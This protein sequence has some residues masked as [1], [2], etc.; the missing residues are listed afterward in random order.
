MEQIDARTASVRI[1]GEVEMGAPARLEELL[2]S[3]VATGTTRLV[4][5]VSQVT[6]L[7]S[8]LL[9][10]LV[11]ISA[12]IDPADGGVAVLTAQTY[13]RHMLEVTEAGGVLLLEESEAAALAALG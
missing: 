9:D 3:L 13:I 2:R 1:T 12:G 4:V 11:R 8:K 7:N 10:S 6:F 5:D